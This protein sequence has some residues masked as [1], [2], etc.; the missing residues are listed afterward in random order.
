MTV[1]VRVLEETSSKEDALQRALA[2]GPSAVFKA[3]PRP[4]AAKLFQ[5]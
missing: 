5:N 1:F 4:N 3:S 2:G